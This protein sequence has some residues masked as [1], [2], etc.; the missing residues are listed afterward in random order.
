LET[1]L[2]FY[3]KLTKIAVPIVVIETITIVVSVIT[4]GFTQH[5]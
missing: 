1:S 2:K 4:K 3:E 5:I